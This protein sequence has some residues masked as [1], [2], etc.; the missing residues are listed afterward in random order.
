MRLEWYTITA[1]LLLTGLLVWLWR[2][3]N[4]IRLF[5]FGFGPLVQRPRHQ[6]MIR[7][8]ETIRHA[9]GEI[10]DWRLSPDFSRLVVWIIRLCLIL[11]YTLAILLLTRP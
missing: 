10:P 7:S 9:E 5:S 11:L 2:L 8:A 1:L 6:T 3:P 4:R